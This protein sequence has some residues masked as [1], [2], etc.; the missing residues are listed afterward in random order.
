MIPKVIHYCWF[1]NNP[2]PPLMVKCIESWKKHCPDYKIIEWNENNFDINFNTYTKEAYESKK[3][4]FVS[5][6]ARLWVMYNYGGIYIDTDVE[7][8]K[9]IDGFL[10]HDAFSG[11]ELPDRVSTGVM[12]CV[13]NYDLFKEFLDYYNEKHFIMED[14]TLDIT[15]NVEIITEILSK[16]NFIP[17]NQLKT[18]MGMVVYPTEYFCPKDWT[19]DKIKLTKNTYGIHY[20]TKTWVPPELSQKHNEQR[21]FR[22]Y[23]KIFGQKN[24]RR[25]YM[26]FYLLKRKGIR[27]VLEKVKGLLH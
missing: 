22:K 23:T 24:G 5:D 12:A 27:A 26:A 11:Y 2:L 18:I 7:L 9:S 1:G 20:F 6:V 14:G 8:I 15:T 13:K 3:W 4:A 16:Y 10:K 19:T 21:K 17:D 25:I